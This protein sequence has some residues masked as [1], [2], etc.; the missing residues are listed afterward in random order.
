MADPRHCDQC[1]TS[2]VPRR[3]HARFCSGRCRVGWNNGKVGDPVTEASA[4]A[5][6]VIAMDDMTRRLPLVRARDRARALAIVGEVVWQV[7]IVDATLVRYYPDRYDG[8][9]AGQPQAAR[10]RIE[11]TLSGLRFV[12]NRLRDRAGYGDFVSWPGSS[13]PATSPLT[14]WVWQPVP[15]PAL[16]ALPPSG[17]SWETTRYRDYREFL[18]RRPVGETFGWATSFLSR[19]AA[20]A[21]AGLSTPAAS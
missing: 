21:I 3:E 1:G 19:A 2:F 13:G 14:A 16:D 5:W 20:P 12:R 9:L 4:L 11:G 17:R 7:T 15:E 8:V 10:R 18:A 6:S